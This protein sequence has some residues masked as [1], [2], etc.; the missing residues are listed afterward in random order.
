MDADNNEVD[1]DIMCDDYSELLFC[2]LYF[3]ADI[4]M[5]SFGIYKITIGDILHSN[6]VPAVSLTQATTFTVGTN[7]TFKT[8]TNLKDFTI[9]A[10]GQNYPF[11][12][13]YNYYDS[14]YKENEQVSG[15]Y[16]FRPAHNYSSLYSK[17]LSARSFKGK[18]LIQI[19]VIKEF[20][21][22]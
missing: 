14:Y 3:Y 1:T 21:V 18:N 22:I 8:N 10:N 15:A 5:N 6:I 12:L 16:I 19:Q 7:Y 17:V 2:N 4:P 9:T 11:S 20:Y 13:Y